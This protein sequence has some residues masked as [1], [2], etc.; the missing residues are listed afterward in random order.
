[1]RGIAARDEFDRYRIS[2]TK[3]GVRMATMARV[4]VGHRATITS[5]DRSEQSLGKNYARTVLRKTRFRT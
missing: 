2:P 5:S 3:G 1:M 4:V